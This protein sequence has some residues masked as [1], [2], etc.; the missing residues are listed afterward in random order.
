MGPHSYFCWFI[1]PYIYIIFMKTSSWNIYPKPWFFQPL[2]YINQRFTLSLPTGAPGPISSDRRCRWPRWPRWPRV[3][4]PMGH[5]L[6]P[7]RADRAADHHSAIGQLRKRKLVEKNVWIGR[8]HGIFFQKIVL[9][10]FN[11]LNFRNLLSNDVVNGLVLAKSSPETRNSP[12]WNQ[13]IDG[14]IPV[15]ISIRGRHIEKTHIAS[16]TCISKL[17][18]VLHVE[19]KIVG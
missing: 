3:V 8:T 15:S 19:K 16:G 1:N 18:K 10:G 9:L 4:R 17:V 6:P 5:R 7:L 13:S 11:S 14:I 12:Y 2:F